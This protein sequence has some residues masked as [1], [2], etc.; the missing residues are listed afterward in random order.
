MISTVLGS[1]GRPGVLEAGDSNFYSTRFQ[2]DL[3]MSLLLYLTAFRVDAQKRRQDEGGNEPN[4]EQC[5]E[6]FA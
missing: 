6:E 4:D 3:C 2:V 1:G 5:T